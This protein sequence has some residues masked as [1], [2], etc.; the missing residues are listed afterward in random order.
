MVIQRSMHDEILISL[1]RLFDTD[2]YENKRVS[3]EYLSQRNLVIKYE[4]SLDESLKKLR[5]KT[6]KLW[7]NISIKDYRDCTLAHNDK[8]TIC[9]SDDLITH[10]FSFESAKDLIETSIDLVLGL[11]AKN[12]QTNLSVILNNKY[13][14]VGYKFI[15]SINKN[16]TS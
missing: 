13:E 6:A 1:S 10:N 5:N 15:E 2:G 9:Y 8:D 14:N 16:I 7:G 3:F 12:S 11:K 4:N